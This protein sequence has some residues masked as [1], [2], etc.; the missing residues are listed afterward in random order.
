L[1]L[2]NNMKNEEYKELLNKCNKAINDCR[3]D[4]K[5]R[6]KLCLICYGKGYITDCGGAHTS[7][8]TFCDGIGFIKPC[9]G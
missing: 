9:T 2:N 1:V 6:T 7:G 3:D 4:M 5:S 8:C